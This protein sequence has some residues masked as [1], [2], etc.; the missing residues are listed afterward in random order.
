M[1]RINRFGTFLILIGVGA[2]A[3]FVVSDIARMP[4]FRFLLWGAG[5][6]VLGTLIKWLNPKP[7]KPTSNRF[8]ILHQKNEDDDR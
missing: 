6:L 3:M 1:M 5:G 4:D 2:I 7:D 8:R